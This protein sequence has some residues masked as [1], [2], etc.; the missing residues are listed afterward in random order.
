MQLLYTNV[1]ILLTRRRGLNHGNIGI[2]VNPPV[3][4]TLSTTVWSNLHNP[5]VYPTVPLNATAA[6]QDQI[7]L[8]HDEI[9]R[10]YENTG[11]MEKAL[12][13]QFIDSVEYTYIKEL[14]NNY[15]G[16]LG[17]VCR[18]LLDF[19]LVQY[20]KITTADL[21]SK[22]QRMNEPIESFF[23]IEKNYEHIDDRVHYVD[24]GKT[25]YTVTQ[26]IQRAR[27]AVLEYGINCDTCK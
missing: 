10:I 20:G 9:W 21:E 24:N 18:D 17:V 26:V 23:P 11:T 2:I 12:D 5:V 7:Q 19:L 6:H 16:S 15:T 3:Y 25:P 14:E 8:Q 13:N 4:I 27:H 22:N 1:A